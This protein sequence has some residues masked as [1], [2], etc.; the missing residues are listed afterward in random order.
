MNLLRE[1]RRLREDL[2]DVGDAAIKPGSLD[3]VPAKERRDS[4]R[5]DRL[6]LVAAEMRG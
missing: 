5:D 4:A 2:S 3:C 1:N 6:M